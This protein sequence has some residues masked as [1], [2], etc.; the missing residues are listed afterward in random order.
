MMMVLPRSYPV[1]LGYI[2]LKAARRL[3]PRKC[4]II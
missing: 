4:K 1:S 2:L 3:R